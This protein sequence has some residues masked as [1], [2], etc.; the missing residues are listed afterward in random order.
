MTGILLF[1]LLS[2]LFNIFIGLFLLAMAL[3]FIILLLGTGSAFFSAAPLFLIAPIC[4]VLAIFAILR[5]AKRKKQND[6][7]PTHTQF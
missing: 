7:P 4:I 2:V 1:L 5:F 3:F 6:T